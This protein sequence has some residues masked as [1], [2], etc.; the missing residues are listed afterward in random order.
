MILIIEGQAM[1]M[2][3]L[4]HATALGLGC[5]VTACSQV[6]GETDEFHLVCEGTK[7]IDAK[8]GRAVEPYRKIFLFNDAKSEIK[9]GG[10]GGT[11]LCGIERQRIVWRFEKDEVFCHYYSEIGDFYTEHTIE[12]NRSSGQLSL[13]DQQYYKDDALGMIT[14]QASCSKQSVKPENR[15]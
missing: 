1:R 14:V 11:E 5:V 8:K 4:R 3:V 7:T 6:V 10:E 12:L 15:I 2:K 13:T 9:E